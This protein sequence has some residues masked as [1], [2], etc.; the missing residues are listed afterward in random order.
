MRHLW[1]SDQGAVAISLLPF[2][3]GLVGHEFFFV[4]S[5]FVLTLSMIRRDEKGRPPGLGRFLADRWC[6]LGP[7]YYVALLLVLISSLP[8][9]ILGY[10]YGP[11]V[12]V[13]DVLA[14]LVFLHGSSPATLHRMY[15]WSMSPIFQFCLVFPLLYT[16]LRKVDYRLAV[17]GA[18]LCWLAFRVWIKVAT[19]G[20]EIL[21]DG[22]IFDRLFPFAAGMGV[23]QWYWPR[24]RAGSGSISARAAGAC[25]VGLLG[26][27]VASQN[28]GPRTWVDLPYGLGY[29]ALLVAVLV[30]VDRG[31][32]L[33]RF[34][35]HP[36]LLWLGTISYSL[37]LTHSFVFSATHYIVVRRVELQPG[38]VSDAA[39]AGVSLTMA[40]VF[41]WGFHRLVEHPLRPRKRTA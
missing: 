33:G 41:A 8:K 9:S 35:S 40:L 22:S 14:H 2:K 17:A 37:Y 10:P 18:A 28:W 5:G 4:L 29:A 34:L 39:T 20:E 32:R 36:R 19:L 38:L 27:A 6:R 21:F 30:S 31:G 7:P 11:N 12:G 26:V 24:R 16:V 1:A 15:L 23:A 3:N 13:R 25:A